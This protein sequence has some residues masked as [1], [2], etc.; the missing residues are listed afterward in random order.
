MAKPATHYV[1]LLRAVNVGGK[2]LA[3]SALRDF[4]SGL[5]LDDAKTLLQSGNLIFTVSGKSPTACEA[6]LESKAPKQLG[7]AVECLVRSGPELAAIIAE[8]PFPKEAKQDPAHLLVVFL[9]DEPSAA[10][11]ATLAAAIKG[12]E[13]IKAVGRQL[14]V[15]YPDGIGRS[16]LTISVIEKNLETRGT[17]RNWNTALKL[18]AL[19]SS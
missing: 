19:M 1:A 2:I 9:K 10:A 3:M 14:Y 11:V 8:N 15:V 4:A 17:G 18:A 7:M 5:G 13:T 12:R 16:K 6:L